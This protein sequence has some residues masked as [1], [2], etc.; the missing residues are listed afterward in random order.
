MDKELN[1]PSFKEEEPMRPAADDFD[2]FLPWA[3]TQLQVH[4]TLDIVRVV[5]NEYVSM[6]YTDRSKAKSKI[7][8]HKITPSKA[9]VTSVLNKEDKSANTLAGWVVSEKIVRIITIYDS[10]D[11][12]TQIKFDNNYHV[13]QIIVKLIGMIIQFQT[14]LTTFTINRGLTASIIYEMFKFLP[15]SHITDICLD[16]TF[17]QQANYHILL[18][19]QSCLRHLSL[20]RCKI[21]DIVVDNIASRLR[22]PSPASKT[23]SLLNLSSNKITDLGAKYIGEALRSNRQLCYLNLASN[24]ISDDGATFILNSLTE[25]PMTYE[26]VIQARTR[27]VTYLKEKNNLITKMMK[28]LKAGDIDRKPLKKKVPRPTSSASGKKGKMDREGSLKSIPDSK[29]LGNVEAIFYEKATNIAEAAIGEF[30]DP[31]CAT[32]INS[33][34]GVVYS[35][36]NNT[37]SY[38]NLAYNNLSYFT[39]RKLLSVL[40][41]QKCLNRKPRGIVNVCIEGNCLPHTCRELKQLDEVLEMGLLASRRLSAVSK[42]RPQSRSGK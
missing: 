12:L 26:E 13:P 15:N 34:E 14:N 33:K 20:S 18:D 7:S 39:L 2:A 28:E 31:F 40:L 21:D 42:K 35:F 3:C 24:S 1:K 30:T 36:G 19:N 8:R 11:N 10:A 17:L 5:Q 9:D 41:Y 32:E 29:S 38:I 22:H 16:N 37:L 23:L 25:F 27:H 6:A 4:A